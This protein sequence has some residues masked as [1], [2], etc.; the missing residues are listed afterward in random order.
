M[1]VTA[2]NGLAGLRIDNARLVS[3]DRAAK[4]L[5][6]FSATATTPTVE[7]QR[8]GVTNEQ[9]GA[10][11]AGACPMSAGQYRVV[12]AL[13]EG[14]SLSQV[15]KASGIPVFNLVK[16]VARLAND[17]EVNLPELRRTMLDVPFKEFDRV[18]RD[19]LVRG[20]SK[21]YQRGRFVNAGVAGGGAAC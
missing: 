1:S 15:S 3:P 6:V 10:L 11:L 9:G 13:A 18:L 5:A 8:Y 17:F 7:D 12:R 16:L 20:N 14:K 4:V 2:L 19:I 21:G